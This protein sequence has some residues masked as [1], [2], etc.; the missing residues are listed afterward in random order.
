MTASR[1]KM[2]LIDR[3]RSF[4]NRRIAAAQAHRESL[5]KRGMDLPILMMNEE[6]TGGIGQQRT[7]SGTISVSSEEMIGTS[8]SPMIGLLL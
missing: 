6:L 3:E 1:H 2:F 5:Y 7:R 8:K 4:M